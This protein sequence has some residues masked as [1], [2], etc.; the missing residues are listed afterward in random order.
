MLFDKRLT[1]L[2][3]ER[4]Y[5]QKECANALKIDS[6]KYNKWENGKN[7]P[8][9]ETVCNLANFF[10]TTTDYLLGYSNQRYK[11]EDKTEKWQSALVSH[12]DNLLNKFFSRYK[13]YENSENSLKLYNIFFMAI[14]ASFRKTIDSHT[15][16]IDCLENIE[17][18]KSIEEIEKFISKYSDELGSVNFGG[19][20]D[21]NGVWINNISD[22]F[23]IGTLRDELEKK[24]PGYK[25]YRKKFVDEWVKHS[26]NFVD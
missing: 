24:V 8:D 22:D 10:N 3:K 6:S 21:S 1:E 18:F 14:I 13:E 19:R 23:I 5:N 9:F 16:L 7:C 26:I 25:E 2:R 17:D 20:Q 15:K 4:G 12:I 11:K